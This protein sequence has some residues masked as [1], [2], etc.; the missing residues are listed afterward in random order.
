MSSE[1][2]ETV[3][4][5]LELVRQGAREVGRALEP[6][7]HTTVVATTVV[8][9]PGETL[10]SERVIDVTGGAVAVLMNWAYGQYLKN[11]D[12][13]AVRKFMRGNWEEYRD[14]LEGMEGP[15]EQRYRDFLEP[16][17]YRRFMTPELIEACCLVGTPDEIAEKL[18]KA[19]A[20][21][22]REIS[23]LC[24]ATS[25]RELLRDFAEVIKRF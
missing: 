21:G 11:R 14:Y 9:R 4:S 24:S 17:H 15:L 8:L 22:L 2:A 18:R 7:F 20:A 23:A 25:Q 12:E 5:R 1:D 3:A 6:D 13:G 10:R 19:E 16:V